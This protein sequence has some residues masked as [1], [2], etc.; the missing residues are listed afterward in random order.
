MSKATFIKEITIIDPQ[1]RL[2]VEVSMFKHQN[3]GIFGIDSSYI[4]SVLCEERTP[5]INDP[6]EPNGIVI[7][8]DI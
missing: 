1:S 7:L 5:S 6:L 3:G 2:P 4:T 8:K